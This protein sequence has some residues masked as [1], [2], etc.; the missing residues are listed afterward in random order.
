[1]RHDQGITRRGAIAL[2][3]AV[4]ALAAGASAH[5]AATDVIPAFR[6]A[7]ADGTYGQVHYR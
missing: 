1:M 6:R 2:A 7:Y 4:P 3:A 5:A